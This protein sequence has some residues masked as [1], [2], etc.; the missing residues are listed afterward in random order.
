MLENISQEAVFAF[1]RLGFHVDHYTSA[2]SED[3]LIQKIGSYHAIGIRS[4]TK[5]TSHVIQAAPKVR[6]LYAFPNVVLMCAF[7]SYSS[8]DVS[9]SAQI[10]SILKLQ[11]LLAFLFS[12]PP[13]PTPALWPSSSWPSSSRSHASYSNERMNC[14]TVFGTSNPRVAGKS[15]E[16]RLA[17]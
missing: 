11:L 4:K 1:R 17:S 6:L 15:V 9:A 14:V 16:R 2:M 3:E 10:K 8:S 5:I 12:T 7:H 13:S